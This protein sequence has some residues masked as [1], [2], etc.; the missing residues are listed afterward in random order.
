MLS[1]HGGPRRFADMNIQPGLP[2]LVLASLKFK[3]Q[4]GGA[5]GLTVRRT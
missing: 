1:L 5:V 4:K 2:L 3:T